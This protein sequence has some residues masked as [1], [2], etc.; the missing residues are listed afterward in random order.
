[1]RNILKLVLVVFG[2]SFFVQAHATHIIGAEVRYECLGNN[3][4]RI[5]LDVY[6]DCNSGNAPFDDPAQLAAFTV[7]G[8]YIPEMNEDLTM[9]LLF[10]EILPNNISNDPC[11]LPPPNVCV[12]RAQY[13]G[14]VELTRP[15]GIYI[16]YQ[17]CCRN[18]TITNIHDPLITGSTY[19]V[20]ISPESRAVCNSSPK[21]DFYPPVFVC[22]NKAIEHDHSA[23]DTVNSEHDSLVYKF[24]TPFVGASFDMPDPPGYQMTSPPYDNVAWIDP[25]Y[26]LDSLL[27]PSS[28][29]ELTI[30]QNTGFITGFPEIMGQFVVGV[31][32]EE[33]RN[34][35]LLSII[36]RDFQYNVGECVK[37]EAEIV[38]DTAQ[39][40]D[41][42]V[43]F[44]NGTNGPDN[45]LWLYV[46][47][48]D[49][50]V[51]SNEVEPTF[52]FPDTGKYEII[53]I[54]EPGYDCVDTVSQALFLQYNS[55]T[56]DFSWEIFD[57][58]NESVLVLEDLS[59]DLVS[60]PN[61]WLWEVAFGSTVWT[62]TAQDTVFVL[63]NPS[64]GTITLTVSSVNGCVQ[65]KTVDF[66]TGLN[67]PVDL[68]PD[69]IQICIGESAEL[70]PNGLDNGY[71]YQ[72]APPVPVDQQTLVNPVVA[73]TLTTTYAVTI[74][75]FDGLCQ[76]E[77]EVTVEVFQEVDLDF[78]P[79]T[80]CDARVVH[81]VNTS[82]N[83]AGG[84]FWD[85]GDLST[86]NDTSGLSDP[87][88]TYPDYGSYLVTLMTAQG[89][90]CTDTITKEII[91]EEKILEA[92][93]DYDFTACE[94][95]QVAITFFDI[96]TNNQFNTTQWLWE[97]SGVYNGTSNQPNPTII[98]TQ[99]GELTVVLTITTD[100]NCVAATDEVVLEIDLTELP[101]LVDGEMI[102]CL[103]GGVQLN[104]C[105]DP[106]YI[107]H[108]S[109]A[110]GLTC[111]DCPNPIA[112]LTETT[113][114]TVV[115]EN[116]SADTCTIIREVSVVVPDDV[117]LVA[118]D[119]V[120]TCD[121]TATISATTDLMPVTFNWFDASGTLIAA[122]TNAITVDVSGY[123]T[124]IV[125]ATDGFGCHYY[126]T[127]QVVGGPADIEAVGQIIACSDDLI[128]VFAT[129]LDPNDTL[130]WQWT[131]IDAFEPGTD[132]SN[133]PDF[134]VAFGHQTLYVHAVNQFGCEMLDTVEVDIID[135]DNMLDFDFEVACN[136]SEVLFIN[137]STGAYS[138]FWE[139]G[140]PTV[141]DDTSHLDNPTYN[142]PDTGTYVVELT[143]DFD[144]DCVNPIQ[145]EVEIATTQFVVDF[146]FE[147]VDC[148][149][150]SVIIQFL[151][152]TNFFVN[153]ITIDSFYW[154]LNNGGT[155]T[156]Q[157]PIF[158]I[159]TDEDLGVTFT[160]WTSNDCTG[161][162]S[163]FI[164]FE[165]PNI[166]LADTIVMCP[167]DSILLNPTGDVSFVYNWFPDES[168]DSTNVANPQVWPSETMTYF[169]EVTSYVP[170][171]CTILKEITV[172]VPDEIMLEIVGGT[173]SCGDPVTLVAS[174]PVSPLDYTWTAMPGGTVGMDAALTHYPTE[175]TW[176]ELLAIDQ[177][178]CRDSA[179]HFVANEAI[180][181]DL[182]GTGA[183]CPESEITLTATN[184]VQ[185]HDLIYNWSA[186]L[187]GAIVSGGMTAT[188]VIL[189]P[190]AG[191]SST[192]SVALQNQH[193]CGDTLSITIDGYDFVPTVQE[194][195]TVCINV[196]TELN[197]GA[198]PNLSYQW[199]SPSGF[200][201]TEPNPI[202][203]LSQTDTFTVVVSDI[204]G[205]DNC[206]DTIDVLAFVPLPIEIIGAVDTF[207]CG[208]AIDLTATTNVD[209]EINWYDL[210]GV[211]LQTGNSFQTDPEI[212]ETYVVVAEDEYGCL[213]SDTF[214]VYNYQ[215]DI[216]LDG[217]GVID[218]CP[219]DSYN[220]CVNNIDP[221]DFLTYNW[222]AITNGQILSGD[223]L[224]CPEVTT[225][226]GTTAIFTVT[227]TNQWGCTQVEDATIETYT[228]DPLIREFLTI[229]PNVP[230]PI[231]P[232]AANSD[233]TYKW[234]PDIGLS[235]DDCPNPEATL[236]VSQQYQVMI[237]GFNGA[238]T[239][240]FMQSVQVFVNPLIEISTIP[241][242][243][244]SLCEP[245]DVTLSANMVS[246]IVDSICW[247]E[248][249]LD[250]LIA[251]GPDVTVTPNGEVT[252]FAVASDTLACMDTAIV[253]VNAFP[254]NTFL[255]EEIV[256]CEED[257][258]LI[259]TVV[260]N[261]PIQEL[262]FSNWQD[263]QYIIDAS[264]DSS[265]IA[266][267]NVPDV[268]LFTVDIENQFG[269]TATDSAVVFYFDIDLTVGEITSTLDTIYFN[270]G[271]FSQLGITDFS[272]TY[273]YE[274]IPQD[275]LNDPFIS[276]PTA[277][278]TETTIYT[279]IITNEEGCSATR[280][281]TIVVLNPDCDEPYIF[282]PNAFTPNGDGDND[283]LF[284][285]SNIIAQMELSIYDRWGELVFRTND[286]TIGWDG[287]YKGKRLAPD[288]FGIYLTADCHNGQTFAKKGNVMILR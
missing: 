162:A 287:T 152:E 280:T 163:E 140:D 109:P 271:D 115:V 278:P 55:L 243:D 169:V 228:F 201:S 120:L 256:F 193:G 208:T 213:E 265:S 113:T 22:L 70:N 151:D 123:S 93:F 202:V 44:G 179:L 264:P 240:S 255:D 205:F 61:E 215:L 184:N 207:T 65:T 64:S 231:N 133:D 83:A 251:C 144:L 181:V 258:E 173:L 106:S 71:T 91:I 206:A 260:N 281:D 10:K 217:A 153:N 42:T 92:A 114:Y 126:D 105:G 142:Y 221:N 3:L 188:P 187:P 245:T 191:S 183:A 66:E 41:L 18:A 192:Y 137:Q 99:E 6:R 210:Q 242:P 84:Y 238:D 117:G 148:G 135:A 45:F 138:F 72:W 277:E 128:D 225:V 17:R 212:E 12:E 63:P 75:G 100:E 127:V 53:L 88:Y 286:Q 46:H 219:Q 39:C 182:S 263:H 249:T 223:T 37:I 247:Y 62:S 67:N 282:L 25:P 111:A 209:T 1:M 104:A 268:S 262:T 239:C 214:S 4:Y 107:Y 38:A 254:I 48:M 218:T 143:I 112:N 204:F 147:Y 103:V 222:E 170:D 132:T 185:D 190:T 167:G 29:A 24:Y 98:V 168:I 272:P 266:V 211:L 130:T 118:S 164:K 146:G 74:T 108:W 229:C 124:Y 154:E 79:D 267:D 121:S 171:T 49:T 47:G 19:F 73:P 284:V 176:Y 122:G 94:D 81:F 199:S 13:E 89:S 177:Y 175:D 195:V 241:S 2:M 23:I 273:F 95:G 180:D 203:M 60:P 233:L 285:R 234:T 11:L 129:N 230:T 58:T 155:S 279:L 134:I 165:F 283:M 159:F 125:R 149:E 172:F 136:G 197:P 7:A 35:T 259:I 85:F 253:T 33:Y 8:D 174:S 189:T 87:T 59:V 21:F 257:E 158:T 186:T 150:D 160:I 97:F 141:T 9:S 32:V 166:P 20:Y 156:E 54:A 78:E 68:L 116:I 275:G 102:G 34:D 96:S 248:G 145:K 26:D 90:V 36:R 50:V 14:I 27:G 270:S 56:A 232:E 246:A 82:S 131:P 198:N 216:L 77:G 220:I 101:C 236:D 261:D 274:W 69:L 196:P 269:C 52:T 16:V 288:V 200:T 110:D 178:G 139:F 31:L 43:T 119:D 235:C 76:S 252:Y 194:E 276:D 244:T 28:I 5:T 15:G 224:A 57:C 51:F 237:M 30:D 250:N 80:D 226:Q 157:N 40:D 227:V 161:S 86:T